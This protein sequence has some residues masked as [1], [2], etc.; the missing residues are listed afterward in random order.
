MKITIE[1]PEGYSVKIEP[2]A[3]FTQP[4]IQPPYPMPSLLNR[5]PLYPVVCANG[6]N[7]NANPELPVNL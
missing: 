4:F 5:G 3:L 2:I 1:V 7:T 6:P